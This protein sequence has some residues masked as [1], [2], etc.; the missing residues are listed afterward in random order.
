M[1]ANPSESDCSKSGRLNEK[2]IFEQVQCEELE[3]SKLIS[4]YKKP[5]VEQGEN[6]H[7]DFDLEGRDETSVT[8]KPSD[9]AKDIKPKTVSF[10]SGKIKAASSKKKNKSASK[11]EKSE[12]G[13]KNGTQTKDKSKG[14]MRR[15]IKNILKE[16]ELEEETRAAQKRELERIQRLQQ[17]QQQIEAN[18]SCGFDIPEENDSATALVDNLQALAKELEHSNLSPETPIPLIEDEAQDILSVS[19]TDPASTSKVDKLPFTHL[20]VTRCPLF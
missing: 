19:S 5:K 16:D 17:Q 6:E 15:N 14:N 10:I 11:E 3:D 9:K 1:E 13:S 18:F 4:S 8:A 20:K 7:A 2:R 12:D